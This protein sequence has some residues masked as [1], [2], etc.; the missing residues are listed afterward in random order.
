MGLLVF[1]INHYR[2]QNVLTFRIHVSF[3]YFILKTKGKHHVNPVVI[4]GLPTNCRAMSLQ[5]H[6]FCKLLYTHM[7]V[8]H[9]IHKI[10]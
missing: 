3:L 8:K 2:F 10:L 1:G 6:Q 9:Y 7:Y 5:E 4:V